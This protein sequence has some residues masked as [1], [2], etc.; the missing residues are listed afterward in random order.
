MIAKFKCMLKS[1]S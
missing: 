1:Q